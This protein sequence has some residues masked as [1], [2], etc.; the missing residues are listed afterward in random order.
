MC[1]ICFVPAGMVQP[2]SQSSIFDM[3]KLMASSGMAPSGDMMAPT[4]TMLAAIKPC[5]S[6]YC[7]SLNEQR[8]KS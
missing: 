8:R 4:S 7:K 3:V 6:P 2:S 5:E 1:C